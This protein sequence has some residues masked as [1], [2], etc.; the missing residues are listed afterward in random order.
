MPLR[1]P[2][3]TD[4]LVKQD[5]GISRFVDCCLNSSS[6]TS[7]ARHVIKTS[8]VPG[9]SGSVLASPPVPILA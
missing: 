9:C 7:P 1:L 5:I 2:S 6:L 3:R 8:F 4:V